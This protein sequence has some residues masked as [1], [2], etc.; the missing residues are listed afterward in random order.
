MKKS[1]FQR[2]VLVAL[3]M[4]SVALVN[5]HV[6]AHADMGPTRS[7]VIVKEGD[8]PNAG[9]FEAVDGV[10]S[11]DGSTYYALVADPHIPLSRL[12][13]IDVATTSVTSSVLLKNSSGDNTVARFIAIQPNGARL[14]VS[15]EESADGVVLIQAA[16]PDPDRDGVA[17]GVLLNRFSPG[18]LSFPGPVDFNA[19]GSR[20]FFASDYGNRTLYNYL[21]ASL[22]TPAGQKSTASSAEELWESVAAVGGSAYAV[23][24]NTVGKWPSNSTARTLLTLSGATTATTSPD[25]SEVWVTRT[26][27]NR[28]VRIAVSGNDDINS[29]QTST[30]A[31]KGPRDVAFAS[32]AAVAVSLGDDDAGNPGRFSLFA[33]DSAERIDQIDVDTAQADP[34]GLSV[35]PDGSVAY[36]I[37]TDPSQAQIMLLSVETN[38]SNRVVPENAPSIGFAGSVAD[39]AVCS[40]KTLDVKEGA[41]AGDGETLLTVET[42]SSTT[43]AVRLVDI[44][45]LATR[46]SCL[47]GTF[48]DELRSFYTAVDPTGEH[49]WT[50]DSREGSAG[51]VVW[52]IDQLTSPNSGAPT[53]RTSYGGETPRGLA[54]RPDTGA[55]PIEAYITVRQ[56]QN[57]VRR[58]LFSGTLEQSF[59]VPLNSPPDKVAASPAH[60]FASVGNSVQAIPYPVFGGN[61]QLGTYSMTAPATSL[62]VSPD[63]SELWVTVGSENQILVLNTSDLTLKSEITSFITNPQAVAFHPTDGTAIVADANGIE[64]FDASSKAHLTGYDIKT[65][66]SLAADINTRS[67][68]VSGSGERVAV[69]DINDATYVLSYQSA[70][71]TTNSSEESSNDSSNDSSS[72]SGEVAP[73]QAPVTATRTTPS[74]VEPATP[75]SADNSAAENNDEAP[76]TDAGSDASNEGGFSGAAEPEEVLAQDNESIIPPWMVATAIGV[77]L[78]AGAGVSTLWLRGRRL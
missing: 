73:P 65:E 44:T 56:A 74:Q 29:E 12:L 59:T 66:Q 11:P 28:I 35:N 7:S 23:K 52:D 21:D 32:N 6:V 15:L 39:G 18:N 36:A 25:E 68:V 48:Q 49:L 37:Y 50:I 19:D 53:A 9:S 16:N 33:T 24:P 40:G 20:A 70:S 43:S 13:T 3:A 72:E 62:T 42:D 14:W 26:S 34:V 5:P 8:F 61:G 76:P 69:V 46:D 10:L 63:G 22:A 77:L 57:Q 67:V 41:M 60:V 51:V 1:T 71:T 27:A 38:F 54:F 4:A 30:L 47:T 31:V 78:L 2:T 45:N 17:N 75:D 64:V 58:V 55:G